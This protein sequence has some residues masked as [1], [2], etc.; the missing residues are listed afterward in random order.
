MAKR[1]LVTAEQTSR[2][3]GVDGPAPVAFQNDC[4]VRSPLRFAQGA[5]RLIQHPMPISDH[6]AQRAFAI[7]NDVVRRGLVHTLILAVLLC[8]TQ[9]C[10]SRLCSLLTILPSKPLRFQYRAGFL[11][12]IDDERMD[13]LLHSSDLLRTQRR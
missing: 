2:T 11:I 10:R 13:G 12:D 7:W 1:P 9:L 3:G 4:T 6:P 8:A 5:K